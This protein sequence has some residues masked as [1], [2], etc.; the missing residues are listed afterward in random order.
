MI[1]SNLKLA[2]VRGNVRLR[3]GEADLPKACVVNISQIITVDKSDLLEKIG[4]LSKVRVNEILNG[5]KLLIEPRD[6]NRNMKE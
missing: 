1:T 6:V 4:T 2:D 3:K 5:V